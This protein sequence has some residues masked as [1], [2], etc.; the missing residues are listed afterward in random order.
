MVK[1]T[2]DE[3]MERINDGNSINWN[4]VQAKALRRKV[5]LAEWHIP[6]CMSESQ[7]IVL[8]KQHA[9]ESCAMFAEGENGTP[10]GMITAL[11]NGGYFETDSTMY[12]CCINTISCHRLGDLL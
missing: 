12:G 6:G 3:A 11:R 4:D 7:C 1:L 10:R 2:F 9:I 8:T 5:W